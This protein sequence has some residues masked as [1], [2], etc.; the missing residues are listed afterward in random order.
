[1]VIAL[2]SK[3]GITSASTL[4]IPKNW[5][6]VW[7]RHFI[8]NQLKGAD[9][10]NAI[11]VNGVTVSGNIASPYATISGSGG[12]SNP[13]AVTP[14]THLTLPTGVG[15]GPNDEFETG[16]TIDTVGTRYVGATPW[17][18]FNLSTATSSVSQGCLVLNP[19]NSG[20]N[21]LNGYSQ[22]TVGA[23]WQYDC[24]VSG[25]SFNA[26]SGR[27]LFVAT[28]SGSAGKMLY[29]NLNM[30]TLASTSVALQEYNTATSFNSTINNLAVPGLLGTFVYLRMTYDGTNLISS[31]ST[32]G[33]NGTYNVINTQTPAFF[34]GSVP[35]M[36]GICSNIQ[37][38][39]QTQAIY[40][41]VRQTA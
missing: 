15:L 1:M 11:G 17:T 34:L 6:P 3:P 10:R 38:A 31:C 35:T 5:D 37:S 41:W 9:V 29:I 25:N 23:T 13:F 33:V 26:S 7:F 4:A 27:G 16:S 22:P 28:A 19:V 40:D 12:G 18:A 32:T 14:D 24:K 30:S 39:T 8:N 2:K 20:A 36:F 21:T